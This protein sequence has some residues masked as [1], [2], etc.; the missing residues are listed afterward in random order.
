MLKRNKKYATAFPANRKCIEM[1]SLNNALMFYYKSE[2]V[3]RCIAFS[4]H[5]TQRK[6]EV[7]MLSV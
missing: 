3:T 7:Q 6:E 5:K 2:S 1:T 4:F